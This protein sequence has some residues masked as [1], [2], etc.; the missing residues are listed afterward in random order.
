MHANP[1][2]E[3]PLKKVLNINKLNFIENI[4]CNSDEKVENRSTFQLSPLR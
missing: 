3:N 4:I 1:S 2:S